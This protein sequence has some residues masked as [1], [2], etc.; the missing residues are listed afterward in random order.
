[1]KSTPSASP[2][3]IRWARKTTSARADPEQLPG[4][5]GRF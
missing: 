3:T 1:M 4:R 5:D 2:A